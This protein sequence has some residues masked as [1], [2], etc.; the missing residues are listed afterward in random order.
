MT[1]LMTVLNNCK[2]PSYCNSKVTSI[3]RHVPRFSVGSYSLEFPTAN[4]VAPSLEVCISHLISKVFSS[5]ELESS[6]HCLQE[7]RN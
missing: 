3:L 2:Y 1:D 4:F 7:L 5:A 6:S